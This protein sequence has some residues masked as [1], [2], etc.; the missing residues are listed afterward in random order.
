MVPDDVPSRL[1]PGKA[2]F[3][4]HQVRVAE[5]LARVRFHRG[6]D[7]NAGIQSPSRLWWREVPT[8]LAGVGVRL[9][10]NLNPG[11]S[12]NFASFFTKTQNTKYYARPL[13]WTCEF[14]SLIR[15]L[16]P[17]SGSGSADSGYGSDLPGHSRGDRGNLSGPAESLI[18][19]LNP[20]SGSGSV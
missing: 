2:V 19:N 13:S 17:D 1:K 12:Q 3:P 15:N 7:E 6:S 10:R 16:N 8:R 14:F 18:R 5:H 11:L 9:I 4:G 20:D